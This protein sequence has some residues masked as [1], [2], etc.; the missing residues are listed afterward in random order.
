MR[1]KDAFFAAC[2]SYV[3][4]RLINR[5]FGTLSFNILSHD[6]TF[7]ITKPGWKKLLHFQYHFPTFLQ[8]SNKY[9]IGNNS[10]M[11]KVCIAIDGSGEADLAVQCELIFFK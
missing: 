5:D 3:P 1:V 8:E 6:L 4:S 11:S 10:K 9:L 7:T 2:N